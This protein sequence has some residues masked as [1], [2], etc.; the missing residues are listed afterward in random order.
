MLFRSVENAI[1]H[2]AACRK[3]G[4]KIVI[5]AV[6]KESCIIIFV[7]DNGDGF[8]PEQY[9]RYKEFFGKKEI[10]GVSFQDKSEKIGLINVQTRLKF[11]FGEEAGL[12][13]WQENGTAVCIR[14]PD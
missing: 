2:G 9:K 5:G 10:T 14:L 3:T 7:W 12:F 4:G 11:T 13:L 6:K 1:Y 8:A